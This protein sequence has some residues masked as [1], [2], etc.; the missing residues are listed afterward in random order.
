MASMP[1]PVVEFPLP[2]SPVPFEPAPELLALSRQAPVLRTVLPGNQTAWLVTGFEQ[3]REVLVDPR[4]SRALVSSPGRE[5]RGLEYVTARGLMGMDPPGHTRLRKLVAGAFTARRMH[6]LA[7][8]VAAIVDE[9]IDRMRAG[10]RPTDLVSAFSTRS[11][12]AGTRPPRTRSAC[13][14]WRCSPTRRSS[15]GCGP[16]RACCPV[17]SRS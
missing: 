13:P 12:S 10:P 17:P 16:T 7:P 4:F 3:V 1:A 14:C 5:R 8:Q 11:C 9:L 6:Q 15:P 2:T